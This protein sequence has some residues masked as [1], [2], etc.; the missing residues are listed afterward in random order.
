MAIRITDPAL[1][2]SDRA[3]RLAAKEARAEA[4]AE[5]EQLNAL[6]DSLRPATFNA[7][8]NNQRLDALRDA[9]LALLKMEKG[10]N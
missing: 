4:R 9:V 2:E 7:L 3:K 8:T 1:S 10:R 5:R 6:L